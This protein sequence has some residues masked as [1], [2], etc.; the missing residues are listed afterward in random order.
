MTLTRWE[1]VKVLLEDDGTKCETSA[2]RLMD[3]G[4]N[5][6]C[7][8]QNHEL[9][10]VLA[11][12]FL[13]SPSTSNIGGLVYGIH[14]NLREKLEQWIKKFIATHVEATTF[15]PVLT[16]KDAHWYSLYVPLAMSI[17]KI[18]NRLKVRQ[19]KFIKQHQSSGDPIQQQ[20][21][22]KRGA[23][24]IVMLVRFCL[25]SVKFITIACYIISK[26]NRDNLQLM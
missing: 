15:V 6:D 10:L 3:L 19:M 8:G 18:L 11:L 16:D 4:T 25:P 12:S 7:S 1:G 26:C 9:A 14:E 17:R 13:I 21:M 22:G 5:K 23:I 20:A 24:T 2:W